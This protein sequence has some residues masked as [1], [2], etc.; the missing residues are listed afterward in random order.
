MAD[1]TTIARPY[2][3]AAFAEAR[4]RGALTA[5]AQ[6]LAT[7][8]QV[9]RDPRVVPL[10]DNPR[11]TPDELAQLLIGIAGQDLSE[12]GRNFLLTLAA[13]HRLAC[14]PEISALFHEL[15]D[16]A[17]GVADV[18]VTSATALDAKQQ[19]SLSAALKRRLKRDVRLHLQIDPTLIGGAVVRA[20]DLVIDGS[21]RARLTRMAYELTA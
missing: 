2:A 17:E 10:I 9:V 13:N 20:G 16:E 18:T 14:L 11:V 8:A 12:D 21:L 7:A 1:R 4:E 6:A 15:K 19:Q 3:K 5:W